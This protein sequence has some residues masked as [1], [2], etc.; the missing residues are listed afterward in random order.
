MQNVKISTNAPI[1]INYNTG[2]EKNQDIIFLEE[3]QKA[4]KKANKIVQKF[5]EKRPETAGKAERIKKCAHF[6]TF[7]HFIQL[8]EKKLSRINLC[9]DRL[10][11]NCQLALSR[12]QI[13]ELAW[14]I[15]RLTLA[16]GETMQFL[17]LT[18]PNIPAEEIRTQIQK[19][20]KASKSFLRSYKIMDYYRSIEITYSKKS[21]TYHPHLHFLFIAPKNTLFPLFDKSLGKYG[22]NPLQFAWAQKWEEITGQNLRTINN[23]NGKKY[24]EATV[25]E[26][27]DK[28]S[29]LE[30]TKYIT[31]PQDMT[32]DVIAALYGIDYE[33]VTNT[34]VAGIRLKTACG[35]FKTLKQQYKLVKEL[36]KAENDIKYSNLEYELLRYIYNNGTYKEIKNNG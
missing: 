1:T 12:K 9:R 30:L 15:E 14:I 29:I 32:E 6:L 4:H 35:R 20:I 31:K 18:A 26:A 7:K 22:A 13:K 11:L 27:R 28:K 23:E 5:Y 36:E 10:C 3:M 2:A 8:D 17:T 16:K 25:Y 19:L 34:G 24:L 33:K 21:N